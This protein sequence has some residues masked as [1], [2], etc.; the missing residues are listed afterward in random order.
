LQSKEKINS[1]GAA[2]VRL[3]DDNAHG[4]IAALSNSETF[5]KQIRDK[6]TRSQKFF[7][8]YDH[9]ILEEKKFWAIVNGGAT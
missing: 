4:A 6:D 5:Y 7:A 8:Y 2:C 1:M 3:T 9:F